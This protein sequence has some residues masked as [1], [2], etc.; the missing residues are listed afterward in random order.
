LIPALGRQ[1]LADL[2]DEL[3]VSLV[4]IVSSRTTRVTKRQRTHPQKRERRGKGGRREVGEGRKREKTE[5]N[6]KEWQTWDFLLGLC[7][8][9]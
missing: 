5:A 2:C 8:E 4:Y 6:R 1:R 9:M 7:Y 3:E